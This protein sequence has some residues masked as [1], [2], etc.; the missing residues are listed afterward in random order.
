MNRTPNT[1]C[2]IC[3]TAIYRRPNE[4]IRSDGKLYCSKDCYGLSNR[5]EIPCRICSTPI[6]ASKN[7]KTCSR[8]CANKSRIGMTY[9]NLGPTPGFKKDKAKSNKALKSWL[10]SIRKNQCQA[11][12][13]DKFLVVHHVIE[14]AKGGSNDESNLLLI[15]SNCHA[16]IHQ[17]ID[18]PA[19]NLQCKTLRKMYGTGA[20]GPP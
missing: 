17:N 13:Y 10:I 15:C 9:K 19:L 16:E 1:F 7:A 2:C 6:L 5:K 4:I 12:S 18:G 20:P 14:K 3:Q 8:A 11:C